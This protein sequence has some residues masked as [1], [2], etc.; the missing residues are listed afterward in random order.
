MNKRRLL[1]LIVAISFFTLS[2]VV[3]AD[4][5][6]NDKKHWE[7]LDT[8]YNPNGKLG[9]IEKDMT[10]QFTEKVKLA[11]QNEGK[12]VSRISK[13][14]VSEKIKP[15]KNKGSEQQLQVQN[16]SIVIADTE[17]YFETFT[18]EG[19]KY[20][21]QRALTS[22]PEVFYNKN[23]DRFVFVYN[24][25]LYAINP[26]N[27]QIEILTKQSAFGKDKSDFEILEKGNSLFWAE[28]PRVSPDGSKVVYY[29]NKYV[30]NGEVISSDG[31]WLYSFA[32]DNEELIL[33]KEVI[34]QGYFL[35]SYIEWV[36]DNSFI[37]TIVAPG[38]Y[39]YFK[40]NIATSQQEFIVE[41][42]KEAIVK[43]GYIVL[44]K[45]ENIVVMDVISNQTL[46][47][48]LPKS[49]YESMISISENGKVAIPYEKHITVID[50][51]VND[52]TQFNLPKDGLYAI[53]SW[54]G[55]DQLVIFFQINQHKNTLILH[56]GGGK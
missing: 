50:T 16:H 49:N 23:G 27:L 8:V 7:Q 35:S 38:S 22:T 11:K 18:I 32:E 42:D 6:Q 51:V 37:Y 39:K 41:N 3:I 12:D 48:S 25:D 1:G 24:Q 52:I 14:I 34:D 31:L 43:D 47:Y 36:D 46:E 40:Y 55:D 21:Q 9:I 54:I 4:Q 2:G 56:A 29:S 30:E 33:H 45:N 17:L 13:E 19:K 44:R 5:L 20:I 10:D 53:Q 28:A 15:K 26:H